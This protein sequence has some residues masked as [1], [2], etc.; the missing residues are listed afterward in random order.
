VVKKEIEHIIWSMVPVS[1]IQGWLFKLE[2]TWKVDIDEKK[3][4]KFNWILKKIWKGNCYLTCLQ[5]DDVVMYLL[6]CLRLY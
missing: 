3:Y 5:W 2:A 4:N 6:D 1:I